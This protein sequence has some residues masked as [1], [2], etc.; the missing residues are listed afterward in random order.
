MTI[1]ASITHDPTAGFRW[2][3]EEKGEVLA[4]GIEI[5][6]TAAEAAVRLRLKKAAV[7]IS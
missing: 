7:P 3:V 2:R 6:Q 1:T 5:S 4:R